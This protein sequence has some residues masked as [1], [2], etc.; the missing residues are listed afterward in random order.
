MTLGEE[1]RMA[2]C[3]VGRMKALPPG[4]KEPACFEAPSDCK[5]ATCYGSQ[6]PKEGVWEVSMSTGKTGMHP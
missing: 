5:T 2:M 4:A 1:D 6:G 3:K